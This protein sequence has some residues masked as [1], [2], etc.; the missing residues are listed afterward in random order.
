MKK[1]GLGRGLGSLLPAM[2]AVEVA[3][4]GSGPHPIPGDS[5]L[6][7]PIGQIDPNRE[8]PRKKFDHDALEQ[9]SQSIAASG[10][11]QPILVFPRE[12]RYQI[13]AGERRWRAARIAGLKTIPAIVRDWDKMKQM[14]A[15]LVE[16]IQREDLNAIEEAAAIRNLMDECGLTQEAVATRLGR[17]RPAVAN[18]L[19]LLSLSKEIQEA[20]IAGELSAGHARVLAGVDDKERQQMLFQ[21]TVSLGWSVRQLEQAASKKEVPVKKTIPQPIEI[22]QMQDRLLEVLGMKASIK[23]TREKGRI[24]L[25][26]HSEESLERLYEIIERE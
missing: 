22:T 7:L 18:L 1:T 26:Y 23:G 11:L 19:R 17:S 13:I 12:G 4:A 15:S 24:V 5:V 2:D 16:N 9:L 25:T 14:E 8:Q 3:P 20:V 10:V 6:E 21:A